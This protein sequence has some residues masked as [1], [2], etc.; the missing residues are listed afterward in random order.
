MK[1]ATEEAASL[2]ASIAELSRAIEKND[3]ESDALR[4]KLAQASAAESNRDAPPE[5]R[6]VVQL[7]PAQEG[8][9]PEQLE[10]NTP[11]R[12]R[13]GG[14]RTARASPTARRTCH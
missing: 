1:L 9:A 11:S 10:V 13:A 14:R 7:G 8:D 3:R 2:D 4:V 6:I 5:L 12:R